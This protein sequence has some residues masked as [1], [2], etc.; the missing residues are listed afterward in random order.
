MH[1]VVAVIY[2]RRRQAINQ[3][4]NPLIAFVIQPF[5][6]N[7]EHARLTKKEEEVGEEEEKKK[8]KKVF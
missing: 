3:T 1:L 7:S 8:E 6:L 5:R 2:C 4:Y